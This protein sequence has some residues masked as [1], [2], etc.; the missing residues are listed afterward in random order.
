M[1]ILV[2]Y[3][4]LKPKCWCSKSKFQRI[5]YIFFT[6]WDGPAANKAPNP[7]IYCNFAMFSSVTNH[8]IMGFTAFF[9]MLSVVHGNDKIPKPLHFYNVFQHFLKC[10]IK[11]PCVLQCFQW[12]LERK[13]LNTSAKI[14]GFETQSDV[15]NQNFMGFNR[16]FFTF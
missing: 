15:P 10:N 1:G 12:C 5:Y 8:R 13:I 3:Q 11:N 9:A 4:A 6:F 14:Q 2:K 7:R 16:F